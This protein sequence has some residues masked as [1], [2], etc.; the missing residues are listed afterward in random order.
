MSRRWSFRAEVNGSAQAGVIEAPDARAARA[1][2][3]ARGL[4]PLSLRAELPGVAGMR[5]ALHAY[6]R[7]RAS[8]VRHEVLSSLADLL[9]AGFSLPDALKTLA[10]RSDTGIGRSVRRVLSNV[11]AAVSSGEPLSIA[12][13]SESVLFDQT[14]AVQVQSA[15]ASGELEAVLRR[16]ALREE[17]RET[18]VRRLVGALAYPAL[19]TS[20]TMIVTV[21]MA[22]TTLPQLVSVLVEADVP[23]PR[24]TQAVIAI[25]DA[26][27]AV[28]LAG[29]IVALVV[30]SVLFRA[31]RRGIGSRRVPVV[32][33]VIS[34]ARCAEDLSDLLA[35]GVSLV[36]GLRATP[37]S[38]PLSR[39][40][41]SAFGRAADRLE[42]GETISAA[43]SQEPALDQELV[44][45]LAHAEDR[46]DIDVV[47]ARYAER[48]LNWAE[49]RIDRLVRFVEPLSIVVLAAIVG[50]LVLAAIQPILAL[51]EVV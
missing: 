1:L 25:G 16:M 39:S 6:R 45:V 43:F 48:R 10:T 42:R 26:I 38:G 32:L 50:V 33:R 47:L 35:A 51:Q 44:S 8:G 23:P 28:V 3:R 14:H 40:C 12:I 5:S 21:V 34:T 7:R 15:E 24:L 31:R 20:A 30:A 27:P 36:G 46:G 41:V 4:R 22:R 49:R 13:G 9:G 2:L 17:R 19:V 18:L 37:K 29:L 11:H